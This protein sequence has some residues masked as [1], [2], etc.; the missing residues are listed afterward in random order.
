MVV[1]FH[2]SYEMYV[3]LCLATTLFSTGSFFSL[4]GV[5]PKIIQI[6]FET[7]NSF[8]FTLVDNCH[9]AI[10]ITL[11]DTTTTSPLMMDGHFSNTLPSH[12]ISSQK[13][14]TNVFSI[15]LILENGTFPPNY[16][17]YGPRLMINSEIS[18]LGLESTSIQP[19]GWRTSPS[20]LGACPYSICITTIEEVTRQ[21]IRRV[22]RSGY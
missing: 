4:K 9:S 20:L 11:N 2:V 5:H 15:A 10:G 12:V 3:R 14:A 7:S 22:C 21:I 6:K 17:A 19:Y 16:T 13:R 18:V 1:V 8:Y